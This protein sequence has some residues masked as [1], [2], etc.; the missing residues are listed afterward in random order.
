M[1]AERLAQWP[2]RLPAPAPDMP[3]V[4]A[5]R[6]AQFTPADEHSADPGKKSTGGHWN[7]GIALLHNNGLIEVSS[8]HLQMAELFRRVECLCCLTFFEAN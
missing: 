2:D 4:L 6:S 3:R 7:S 5:S 1:P 8:G